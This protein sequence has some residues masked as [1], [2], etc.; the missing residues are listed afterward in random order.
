VHR[1]NPEIHQELEINFAHEYKPTREDTSDADDEAEASQMNEGQLQTTSTGQ[2]EVEE[3][4]I[5]LLKP[6]S[7]GAATYESIDDL[8]N[9]VSIELK[10]RFDVYC[11]TSQMKKKACHRLVNYP[12]QY[13]V[14]P[15]CVCHQIAKRLRKTLRG[16]PVIP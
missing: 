1:S 3:L 7:S 2:L 9:S 14:R 8:P 5:V 11:N 6:V 4:P 10:R 13:T 12:P 16:K 15:W